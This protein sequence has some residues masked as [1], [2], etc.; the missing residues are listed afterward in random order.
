MFLCI[1]IL[2]AM[3]PLLGFAAD[4]RVAQDSR[5]AFRAFGDPLVGVWQSRLREWE[6]PAHESLRETQQVRRFE[7]VLKGTFL[8]ESVFSV[9]RNGEKELIAINLFS[10]DPESTHVLE[11]GFRS[12]EPNRRISLD[13]ELAPNL[14]QLSGYVSLH[15]DTMEK[16][17]ELRRVEMKWL[18]D[19]RWSWRT[20]AKAPNGR[21]YLLEEVIN[22]R[23]IDTREIPAQ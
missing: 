14:R 19:D 20:Y 17:S 8:Q 3:L 7:W 21:E 15:R 23:R 6:G 12:G 5:Q 4:P 1:G 11:S 16:D 9:M 13:A 10:V 2:L 22:S 18:E